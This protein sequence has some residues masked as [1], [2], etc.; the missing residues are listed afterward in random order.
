MPRRCTVCSLEPKKRSKV[1]RD[2]VRGLS[3]YR[4]IAGRYDVSKTAV[5]RHA[6]EH[7][8]SRLLLAEQAREVAEADALLA[9]LTS[10]KVEVEAL[11]DKA[12]KDEDTDA[13]YKGIALSLKALE[14]QAKVAQLIKDQPSINVTLVNTP[15]WVAVRTTIIE[16]L[17]PYPDAKAAVVAALVQAEE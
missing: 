1:D 2:L 9:E 17:T 4:D 16:A 13:A 14:L 6:E 5:Q 15:E 3:S 8:P 11:R 7:L 10:I 12:I